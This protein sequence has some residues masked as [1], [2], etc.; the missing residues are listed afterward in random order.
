VFR[1]TLDRYF[2]GTAWLRLR[3]DRFDRLA[4]Y[5]ARHAL[6]TWEAAIDRLLEEQA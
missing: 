2:N 3:K 6:P 5:K 1:A 4:A